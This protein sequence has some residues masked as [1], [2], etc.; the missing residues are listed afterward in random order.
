MI[1]RVACTVLLF[2]ASSDAGGLPPAQKQRSLAQSCA[3]IATDTRRRIASIRPNQDSQE[4]RKML[5][6]FGRCL[7]A[8]RGAWA[9]SLDRVRNNPK[10]GPVG[11]FSLVHIAADGRT[12][13]MSPAI[14]GPGM[15]KDVA[16][17]DSDNFDFE[18]GTTLHLAP[19][20]V[21]DYDE[22]GDAEI[23][24]RVGSTLSEEGT[25]EIA[26]VWT[27]KN[28][29]VALY[30]PA[31]NLIAYDV[32]DA[33]GDGRPDLVMHSPYAVA[34][35]GPIDTAEL[36]G[37]ALLAHSLPGGGFSTADAVAAAAARVSCPRRPAA[38]VALVPDA[39]N[40]TERQFDV[41]A[42]ATNIVCAR[43]W[44]AQKDQV[45]EEILR[46]CKYD[47]EKEFSGSNCD[48][49]DIFLNWARQRPPVILH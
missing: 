47:R 45:E 25:W 22:D 34:V 8:G 40:P 26:R 33:D 46:D 9:L 21:F 16:H 28:G 1:R 13:S 32:R 31:R 41:G 23:V 43:L 20:V 49:Q 38:L 24:L 3:S 11:H 18:I 17:W 7:P 4:A 29:K 5:T 37:P 15:T 39:R 12:A 10:G 27:A 44:G 14:P 30:D 2:F 19:P 36:F 42:T 35:D 48:Y 6:A